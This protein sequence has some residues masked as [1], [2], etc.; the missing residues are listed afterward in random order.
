MKNLDNIQHDVAEQVA[1]S[2]LDEIEYLESI[3]Q[4]FKETY[5][6]E[7]PVHLLRVNQQKKEKLDL[8][9]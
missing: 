8:P 4:Y 3:I 2:L 6:C 9:F 5:D 7:I 1:S